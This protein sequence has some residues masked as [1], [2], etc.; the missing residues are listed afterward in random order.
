MAVEAIKVRSI[1]PR[2]SSHFHFFVTFQSEVKDGGTELETLLQRQHWLDELK[3]VIAKLK[4][5]EKLRYNLIFSG[6]LVE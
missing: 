4:F 6:A 1:N 5:L 3:K 2:K